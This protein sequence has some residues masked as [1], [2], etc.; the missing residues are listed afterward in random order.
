MEIFG[1]IGLT[2]AGG[3]VLFGLEWLLVRFGMSVQN[4]REKIS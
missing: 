2:L 1:Y 4:R 3:L